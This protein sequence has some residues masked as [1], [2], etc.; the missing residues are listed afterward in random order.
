MD[1]R[2]LS[3]EEVADYLGVPKAT[4]YKWRYESAGPRGYRVGRHVRF[5]PEDSTFGSP[6]RPT[7]IVSDRPRRPPRRRGRPARLTQLTAAKG[8]TATLEGTVFLE[9]ARVWIDHGLSGDVG[10][11]EA[12]SAAVPLWPRR[13]DGR[14]MRPRTAEE[15]PCG[16][17]ASPRGGPSIPTGRSTT[18]KPNASQ[19]WRRSHRGRDSTTKNATRFTGSSRKRPRRDV[20]ADAHREHI[21]GEAAR[22]GDEVPDT[23]RR[24]ETPSTDSS[25]VTLYDDDA[26]VLLYV[27]P[28][29]AA[30]AV[31]H[32]TFA[33]TLGGQLWKD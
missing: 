21:A 22:L 10:V 13:T 28:Y 16:R 25:V 14:V 24:S 27:V 30:V 4:I 8:T 26:P 9:A 6:S 11:A 1:A 31:A 23:R 29:C 20:R 18:R 33:R 2:L 3:V 15:A 32:D 19:R 12:A 17:R 7:P 5:R